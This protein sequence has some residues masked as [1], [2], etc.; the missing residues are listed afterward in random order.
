MKK[1]IRFLRKVFDFFYKI[2]FKYAE[3]VLL[4][5]VILVSVH[6][7]L[8]KFF[9]YSLVWTEEV[10]ILLIVWMAF[11]SLSIGV[12]ENLHICISLFY[13]KLPRKFQKVIDIIINLFIMA[14]GVVLTRYGAGLIS[15][16]MDST[17]PVTGWPTFILYL[18]IPVSGAYIVYFS[19]IHI[20]RFLRNE[21]K[22]QKGD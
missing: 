1:L 12:A 8:R 2:L 19:L 11:I 13:D 7:V 9:H 22:I 14:S 18:M 21:N 3:I 16:T 15:T 5:I 17:L 10:A 4:F 20:Y 6:V